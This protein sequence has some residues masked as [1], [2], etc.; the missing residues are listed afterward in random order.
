[1]KSS[2]HRYT[3]AT[4]AAAAGAIVIY[5]D[6]HSALAFTSEIRFARVHNLSPSRRTSSSAPPDWPLAQTVLS[7]V[8]RSSETDAVEALGIDIPSG[9]RQTLLTNAHEA[10]HKRFWIVDNSGSM[11]LDDGHCL[12]SSSDNGD[13]ECSRWDE[14]SE[15]VECHIHLAAAL[16]A[17]SEFRLLNPPKNGGPLVRGPQSFRVGYGLN[18]P[19]QSAKDRKRAKNIMLRNE[20]SGRTP[21]PDIIRELRRDII[22]MLPTLEEEGSKVC[23]VIA[24]D[25][26]NV[27]KHNAGLQVEEDERQED[28][29]AALD[30]LTGLPVCVVVRL[31]TDFQPIVEF[32]NGLDKRLDWLDIDVVD[33]H[34]SEAQEVFGHNPWLNY[35][36]P[37]HR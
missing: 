30:S 23:I 32:F 24:T 22:D 28:L 26:Q 11:S 5:L 34:L 13:E 12:L 17:P 3:H 10:I 36:R 9:L 1:M 8:L 16:G 21:L 20:P 37:L 18:T 25:G 27:N 2:G 19:S 7:E 4:V 35:A 6:G 31:C 15:T 33:D 29:V 14:V